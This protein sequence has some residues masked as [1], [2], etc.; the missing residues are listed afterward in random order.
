MSIWQELNDI[1]H[2]FPDEAGEVRRVLKK[3]GRQKRLAAVRLNEILGA[4]GMGQIPW[5]LL[6]PDEE[7][8]V[9]TGPCK[10]VVEPRYTMLEGEPC[11]AHFDS[12]GMS[13]ELSGNEPARLLGGK[14]RWEFHVPGDGSQFLAQVCVSNGMI[15]SEHQIAITYVHD[16][17]ECIICPICKTE[18]HYFPGHH[19]K[20]E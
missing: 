13:I 7:I 8:Q 5:P 12:L 6:Q 4:L 20:K 14:T 3:G 1:G 15:A 19:T 9:S 2:Y 11:T 16:E 17:S 18:V 10:L